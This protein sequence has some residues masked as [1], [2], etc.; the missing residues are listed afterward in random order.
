M[1][2]LYSDFRTQ[3]RLNLDGYRANVSA[4]TGALSRLASHGLLSRHGTDSGI[5][6]LQVDE[7]LRRS[8]EDRQ[9]GVPLA[10]GAAVQD[11]ITCGRFVALH[12]FLRSPLSSY[13]QGWSELPWAV[14]RW[15]FSQLGIM[16]ATRGEDKLPNGPLIS[17]ANLELAEKELS[18]R[19]TSKTSRFDRVFTRLQFWDTFGSK[20]VHQQEVSKTDADVLLLYLTR[21]KR[22]IDYD[23]KTIRIR[24]DGEPAGITTEDATIASIKEL[25]ASLEHQTRLLS[26]RIENLNLEAKNAVANKNR[27]KALS[28]LKAKKTIESSL[29]RRYAALHQLEEVA[30]KLEQASDN[31]QIVRVLELSGSVLKDLNS[32]VG[33]TEK[34]ESLQEQL[35]EQMNETNEV[36]SIL[37]ESTT[38]V[39][40]DESQIE[41]ELEALTQAHDKEVDEVGKTERAAVE[42]NAESEVQ[43]ARQ[44][45]ERL[46]PVPTEVGLKQES[47]QTPKLETGMKNLSLTD[48]RTEETS[49]GPL[50]NT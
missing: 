43:R 18:R 23:G 13:R 26:N 40:V 37:A 28:A 27:V 29:V 33:S 34:L 24:R 35:R 16:D 22:M 20:L 49:Q 6:V 1:P 3:R 39:A 32:R 5:I 17:V 45:L 42:T 10:L 46:P 2:A 47:S 41:E 31:I 7:T 12:D 50:P 38:N 25:T 11:A 44:E 9:W 48:Q 8:L 19:M 4:W 15:T 36:A 30:A 14:M 21:D